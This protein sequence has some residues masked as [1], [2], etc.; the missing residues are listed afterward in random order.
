MKSNKKR[1]GTMEWWRQKW[2]VLKI[3]TKYLYLK[4]LQNIYIT[5]VHLHKNTYEIQY[6]LHDKI[7]R[8]RTHVRRGPSKIVQILDHLD[9]DITEDV[10]TY[11]GPNE[12]FHGQSVCP[13][14]IGY[15]RV[16]VCL[17]NGAQ[18]G[19][20]ADEPIVVK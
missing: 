7:Y 9:N 18:V 1:D 4:L 11:M 2:V 3:L 6:V 15:E 8:I 12:D 14:D 13:Q 10:R 19:F 5:V 16:Y 20:A 17:R